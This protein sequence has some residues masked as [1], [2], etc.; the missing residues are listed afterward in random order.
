MHYLSLV[1][2]LVLVVLLQ[3]E[4]RAI[5]PAPLPAFDVTSLDGVTIRSSGLPRP[6]TWLL[7]YVKPHCIPC[8]TL[9]HFFKRGEPP[10][11]SQR[12]VVVVGGTV[13]EAREMVGK[14]PDLAQESW[15]TDPGQNAFTQLQLQGAS[16]VLG[17]RQDRVEWSIAGVLPDPVTL[18]SILTTWLE[19]PTGQ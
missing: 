14:F 19:E 7:V 13:N 8:E 11:F 6:G 3:G 1:V 16:M 2:F 10:N 17:V 12:I 15:Y 5:E 9:L 18:H 4:A